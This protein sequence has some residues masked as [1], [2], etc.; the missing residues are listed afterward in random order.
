MV[1]VNV[2]FVGSLAG[3]TGKQSTVLH[4]NTDQKPTILSLIKLLG[5]K[6]GKE[7]EKRIVDYGDGKPRLRVLIL[8][9]DVEINVLKGLD[10][11]IDENDVVVL[12]P[13]SHGG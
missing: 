5:E 3:L 8:K 11:F 1:Q 7:V 4:L 9:N 13:V 12:I 2:K 6:F 10:T